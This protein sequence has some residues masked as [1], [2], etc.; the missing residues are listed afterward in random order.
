MPKPIR[1][2]RTWYSIER[3]RRYAKCVSNLGTL[4]LGSDAD[5]RSSCTNSMTG[6]SG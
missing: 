1:C 5:A 2:G 6:V 3:G 4:L